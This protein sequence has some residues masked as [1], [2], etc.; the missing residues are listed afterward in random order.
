MPRM[1]DMKLLL[2]SPTPIS[3]R[4]RYEI[5]RRIFSLEEG[6]RVVSKYDNMVIPLE[7]KMVSF[8]NLEEMVRGKEDSV[9]ALITT[10]RYLV[11]IVI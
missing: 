6:L 4:V 9:L 8:R 1:R 10:L 2:L 11:D 5:A 3:R 7:S